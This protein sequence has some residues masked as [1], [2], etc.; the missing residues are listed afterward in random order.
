MGFLFENEAEEGSQFRKKASNKDEEEKSI[1]SGFKDMFTSF[2]VKSGGASG[3]GREGAQKPQLSD[4][5]KQT[6]R[7]KLDMIDS[8]LKKECL[9]CGGV[10]I[11]MIDNDIARASKEYEFGS[12]ERSDTLH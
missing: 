4:E 6:I 8:L 2:Q 5:Q 1:L 3:L 12:I 11:D 7:H 9:F 10:L